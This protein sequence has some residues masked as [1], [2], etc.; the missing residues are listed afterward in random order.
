MEEMEED[1]S[2]KSLPGYLNPEI[3][4]VSY[5]ANKAAY[6][7]RLLDSANGRGVGHLLA[8]YAKSFKGKNIVAVHVD[9]CNHS[10]IWAIE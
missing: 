8:N 10:L 4:E 3:V 5:H 7:F 1:P 6:F 2:I 9:F